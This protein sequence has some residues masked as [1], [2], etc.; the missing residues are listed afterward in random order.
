MWRRS[1]FNLNAIKLLAYW[2]RFGERS[3]KCTRDI[4]KAT[5]A[6]FNIWQE[7]RFDTHTHTHLKTQ[8]ASGIP[9]IGK[10]ELITLQKLH[11][12]K[13][14]MVFCWCTAGRPIANGFKMCRL[15]PR[16]AETLEGRKRS[17]SQEW[18]RLREIRF[19]IAPLSPNFSTAFSSSQAS[20]R[21]DVAEILTSL[22]SLWK[23]RP[24]LLKFKISLC[25]SDEQRAKHQLTNGGLW[26]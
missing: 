17:R 15:W 18:E 11:P 26:C 19:M 23:L 6:F 1:V 4:M 2:H 7:A 20:K 16:E 10:A 8:K 24:E 13:Q 5:K 25:Q 14:F 9:G 3:D 12:I 22:L 21:C